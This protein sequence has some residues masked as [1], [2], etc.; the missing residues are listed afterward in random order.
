MERN[1]WIKHGFPCINV[2]QVPR[3]MLN[4]DAVDRVFQHLP[5]DLPNV[6]V[7]ENNVWSLLLHKFN[8]NR[9][10]FV[11]FGKLYGTIF[12]HRLIVSEWVHIFLNIRFPGPSASRDSRW[13]HYSIRP[14]CFENDN[15]R[16]LLMRYK[17][18]NKTEKGLPLYAVVS[19]HMEPNP[20]LCHPAVL[21][22]RKFAVCFLSQLFHSQFD[23][24]IIW[25]QHCFRFC[26]TTWWRIYKDMMT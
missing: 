19:M 6:N 14:R 12:C 15:T 5:R 1:I 20:F 18:I 3:E 16:W 23:I 9:S 10:I 24:A 2:C 17:F 26:Y 25:R 21:G 8:D 7:L 13:L 4:T 11:K 22:S